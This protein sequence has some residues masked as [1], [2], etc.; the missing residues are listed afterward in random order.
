MFVTGSVGT[1]NTFRTRAF[2][3]TSGT[4]EWSVP[5]M[6]VDPAVSGGKVYSVDRS[7]VLTAFDA[8]TGAIA[9]SAT[10]GTVS[11]AP[12][13]SGGLV[14]AGGPKQ[15]VYAYDAST[16]ALV[17]SV[18]ESTDPA[19]MYATPA[20]ANGVLYALSYPTT[21]V[22]VSTLRAYDA[23][24]G[25]PRWSKSIGTP[26][27]AV[28]AAGG[29]LFLQCI[30]DVRAYDASDGTFLW[31]FFTGQ[32]DTAS[33]TRPAID[34]STVFALVTGSSLYALDAATGTEKWHTAAS[35]FNSPAVA[36]GVVY[37]TAYGTSQPP[38]VGLA[39]Y[40]AGTGTRL[41]F[42]AGPGSG[43]ADVSPIVAN[44]RVYVGGS[45]GNLY[46]YSLSGS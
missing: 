9:W 2:D 24:T 30:E 5:T 3:A 27:W 4:L 44:G 16:G 18:S 13:L 8:S 6:P 10:V 45:D 23:S 22:P 35:A 37:T 36:N 1:T 20:I 40:D 39:A 32:N 15:S 21:A 7:G 26:A 42:S 14:Y 31:S 38:P 46:A 29:R 33:S 11:S 12:V 19:S 17:W 43:S 28:A 41:F 34:G 25:A